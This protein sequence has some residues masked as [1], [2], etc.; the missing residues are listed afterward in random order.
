MKTTTTT[1]V[2]QL[3][4]KH[5][6]S[7]PGIKCALRVHDNCEVD[8]AQVANKPP[9]MLPKYNTML[10]VVTGVATHPSVHGRHF[11]ARYFVTEPVEFLA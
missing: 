11:L 4:G 10:L 5:T 6:T 7:S 8:E 9:E 3:N 2:R 1:P